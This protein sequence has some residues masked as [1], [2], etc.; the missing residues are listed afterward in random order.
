MFQVFTGSPI[1]PP[2]GALN[3]YQSR[4]LHKGTNRPK[5][6]ILRERGWWSTIRRRSPSS[7]SR[8]TTKQMTPA[9]VK[10]RRTG[11][12]RGR[13]IR[14]RGATSPSTT[15]AT[16]LPLPTRTTNTRRKRK[17][18]T[19]TFFRLFSYS[20][21]FKCSLAFHSTW[22]TSSL[23]WRGLWILESQNA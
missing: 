7:M 3:W 19:R 22:Q 8:G 23:W 16:S 15:T 18:L 13:S 21:K 4:S 1:H 6:W 9:Q 2:L 12:R 5:R 17:R 11:R 10:R 14:I 20:A